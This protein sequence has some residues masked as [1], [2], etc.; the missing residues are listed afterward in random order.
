MGGTGGGAT[1]V[2]VG[3]G[4]GV[5][6]GVV[7]VG[8][9]VGVRVRRG[10]PVAVGVTVP[11]RPADGL[12]LGVPEAL[13]DEAI[14]VRAGIAMSAPITKKTAAMTTLGNC[15][16]SSRRGARPARTPRS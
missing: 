5:G 6:R 11:V 7:R 1:R 9:G 4:V 3:V 2:R 15:I 10:V 16:A 8:V 14:R 12:G 13:D